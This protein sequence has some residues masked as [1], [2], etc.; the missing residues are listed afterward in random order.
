MHYQPR[1]QVRVKVQQLFTSKSSGINNAKSRKLALGSKRWDSNL[2]RRNARRRYYFEQNAVVNA[3]LLLCS[4][5]RL[6]P[7]NSA[8]LNDWSTQ[9]TDEPEHTAEPLEMHFAELQQEP[10]P[11]LNN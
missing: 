7:S 6:D 11:L 4:P 3:V 1:A 9:N 5:T 8:A 10:I 2:L